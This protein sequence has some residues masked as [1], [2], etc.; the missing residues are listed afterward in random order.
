V[1]SAGRWSVAG[2]VLLLGAMAARVG[3]GRVYE[4]LKGGLGVG[5]YRSESSC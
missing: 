2:G 4:G 1:V 5:E 3:L